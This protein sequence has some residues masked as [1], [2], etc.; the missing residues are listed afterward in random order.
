MENKKILDGTELGSKSETATK[1]SSAQN[2]VAPRVVKLDSDATRNVS[3][4]WFVHALNYEPNGTRLELLSRR[5]YSGGQYTA[6]IE[7]ENSDALASAVDILSTYPNLSDFDVDDLLQAN[8]FD[9]NSY[10]FD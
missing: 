3:G 5:D 7:F 1:Q 2:G 8:G 6:Y 10:Y 9:E 4:G